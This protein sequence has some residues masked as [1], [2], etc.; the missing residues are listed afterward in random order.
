[1]SCETCGCKLS[2]CR[3][4][5]PDPRDFFKYGEMFMEVELPPH[6]VFPPGLVR[7]EW[8]CP[9]CDATPCDPS[10]CPIGVQRIHDLVR[11]GRITA[12]QGSDLLELRRLLRWRRRPWWE[13]AAIT[14]WRMLWS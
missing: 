12:G 14:I 13:R 8:Y 5:L 10:V 7:A 3:C 1:M 6:S 9:M 4:D 2:P 11:E